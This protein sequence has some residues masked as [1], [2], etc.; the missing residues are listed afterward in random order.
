VVA[1]EPLVLAIRRGDPLSSRTTVTL[2]QLREQPMIT[3]VR[4]SGLRT[5]LENA[6][7]DAGFVPGSRRRR[8][9]SV[10]SSSL[11]PKGSA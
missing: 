1:T 6:C 4:G 9:S 2:A 3:L 11:P 10:P 7:R 5:V 8:A